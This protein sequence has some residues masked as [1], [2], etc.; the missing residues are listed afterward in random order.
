M[1]LLEVKNISVF[2]DDI[3]VLR[4]VSLEIEEGEMVSVVGSNGAGKSTLVR[5]LSGLIRPASGEIWFHGER[6]DG[7]KPHLTTRRGLIQVPE[8]KQLW[9]YMTV[10][11]HL[12]V[13]SY[14]EEARERRKESLEQVMELFPTLKTKINQ[15]AHTL[16]GGEQQM[17]ATARGLMARPKLLML[18]EPSLGLAPLL[19]G[20]VFAVIQRLNSQGTTILLIE[21]NLQQAL[22]IASRGYVL[23]NGIIVLEGKGE[24]LLN[25]PRLKEAYLGI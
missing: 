5:T 25:S 24:E 10:K 18:D 7:L 21:Q 19:V 14:L 9:P 11:E 20:A 6:I 17:L 4:D 1:A 2:Y 12:E 15:L 22:N 13:G 23:E 3:G 8:G 16:S